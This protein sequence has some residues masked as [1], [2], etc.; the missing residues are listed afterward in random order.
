MLFGSPPLFTS[1]SSAFYEHYNIK[2]GTPAIVALKDGDPDVP[3][4]VYTFSRPLSTVQE[5]QGLVDWVRVHLNG[6][7]NMVLND[8]YVL[9]SWSTTASQ[10][11]SSSTR[12][13]SRTS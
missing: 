3:A 5:R 2:P 13:T 1:T 11:R 12:T 9:C 8:L 10:R 4:A 6:L 7:R